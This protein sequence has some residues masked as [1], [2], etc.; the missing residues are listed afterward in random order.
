MFFFYL[1]ITIFIGSILQQHLTAILSCLHDRSRNSIHLRLAAL[2]LI[3]ILRRQGMICPLDVII[4][5]IACATDSYDDIKRL[6][7]V[8]IREIDDMQSTFVDNRL[9]DGFIYTTSKLL[10]S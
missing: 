9:L 5:V 10:Y 4:D 8:I 6:S 7:L 1:L 3:R 2:E